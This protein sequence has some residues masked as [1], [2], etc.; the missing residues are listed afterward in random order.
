MNQPPISLVNLSE[1]EKDK[2]AEISQKKL[3]RGITMYLIP[4]VLFGFL[5]AY[6]NVHYEKFGLDDKPDLREWINVGLVFLT[7]LPARLFV[8]VL[9]RHRKAVNAWQKKVIRGKITN[10][11]GNVITLVNQKIKLHAEDL[12]KVKVDDE[13][14]VSALPSGDIILSVEIISK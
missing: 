14:I 4:F 9:L 12:S 5:V 8:N 13:V 1:K 7:I 2:A 11:K 6:V 10:I 3:V